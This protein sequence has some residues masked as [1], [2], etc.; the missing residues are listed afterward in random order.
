MRALPGF[1]S[2]V[3]GLAAFAASADDATFIKTLAEGGRYEV[4]AGE[5]AGN[6]GTVAIPNMDFTQHTAAY[7]AAQPNNQ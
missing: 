7:V 1:L 4:E 6:K 5:L 3:L 2:L